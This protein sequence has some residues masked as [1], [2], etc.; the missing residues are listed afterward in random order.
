MKN[1][2][3]RKYDALSNI[4]HIENVKNELKYVDKNRMKNF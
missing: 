3:K 4:I 2:S 1:T